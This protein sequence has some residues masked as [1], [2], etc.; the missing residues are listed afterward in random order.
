MQSKDE[1]RQGLMA[2]E[3]QG[4]GLAGLSVTEKDAL[5]R[6]SILSRPLALAFCIGGTGWPCGLVAT[7]GLIGK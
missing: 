7:V 1:C 5:R 2:G 4:G 6:A 3:E